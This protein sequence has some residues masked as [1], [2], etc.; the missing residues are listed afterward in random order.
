MTEK[1]YEYQDRDVRGHYRKINGKK[2]WIKPHKR[3]LMCLVQPELRHEIK[4]GKSKMLIKQPEKIKRE[5]EDYTMMTKEI[6]KNLLEVIQKISENEREFSIGLDF[7]RRRKHPEQMLLL[8][9]SHEE[10]VKFDDYEIFGHSHPKGKEPIPSVA[11]LMSMRFLQP[12]F[13]VAGVSGKIIFM[14]IDDKKRY[15]NWKSNSERKIEDNTMQTSDVPFMPKEFKR[16]TGSVFGYRKFL[17][18]EDGRDMFFRKTGVKIYQ[19]DKPIKVEMIDL[20]D[21]DK[22]SRHVPDHVLEKWDD[23]RK[24]KENEKNRKENQKALK[25]NEE[26]LKR[27]EIQERKIM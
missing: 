1:Q 26:A 5:H 11:D 19:V 8:K 12:E 18:T 24:L 17:E 21:R 13:I 3:S 27:L 14:N 4:S 23:K 15:W 6:S 2:K 22:E 7:E 9:G 25:E 20:V 16:A 10:T